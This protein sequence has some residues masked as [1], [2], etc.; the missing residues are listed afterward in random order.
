MPVGNMI[1][2]AAICIRMCVHRIESWASISHR[3]F[4]S[5][6]MTYNGIGGDSLTIFYLVHMVIVGGDGSAE[7]QRHEGSSSCPRLHLGAE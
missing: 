3:A 1:P 2:Q 5:S 4:P 7:E 6:S